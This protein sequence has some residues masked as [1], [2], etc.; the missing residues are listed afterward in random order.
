MIN[1]IVPM[2][3]AIEFANGTKEWWFKGKQISK[4]EYYS[5]EFQVKIVM[6]S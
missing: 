5:N 6:E 3:P 2:G 4:E 1:Y